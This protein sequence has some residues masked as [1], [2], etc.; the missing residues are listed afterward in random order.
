MGKAWRRSSCLFRSLYPRS[1]AN[2]FAIVL[3]YWVKRK[4][5]Q[6]QS[7]SRL[8]LDYNGRQEQRRDPKNPNGSVS[9]QHVVNALRRYGVC[10]EKYWPYRAELI[11]KQP[12]KQA[13]EHARSKV[14]DPV[15]VRLNMEHIKGALANKLPVIVEGSL[16]QSPR[17][18]SVENSFAAF[19]NNPSKSHSRKHVAIFAGYDDQKQIFIVRDLTA[20]Q[21]VKS[22]STQHVFSIF[23][24]N[25][26]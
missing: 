24:K 12:S 16:S 2:A 23:S 25:D 10:D 13:Y 15:P 21:S 26:F 22:C 7:A 17:Q 3:E 11:N 18:E 4:K 19:V 20:N 6:D 5:N 8:F 1:A 14:V 9:I